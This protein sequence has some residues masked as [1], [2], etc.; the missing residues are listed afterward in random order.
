V[1]GKVDAAFVP[2]YPRV[3]ELEAKKEE[4]TSEVC[5]FDIGGM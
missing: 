1:D 2:E 4:T 5:V 3:L